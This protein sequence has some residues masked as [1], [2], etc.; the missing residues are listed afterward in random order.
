MIVFNIHVS[1]YKIV[2]DQAIINHFLARLRRVEKNSLSEKAT[3]T[4]I[5]L[6]HHVTQFGLS[7]NCCFKMQ[8][9][10]ISYLIFTVKDFDFCT[11]Q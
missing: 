5:G 1:L 11:V 3:K 4:S 7:L 6:K 9:P 10:S 8:N 2:F